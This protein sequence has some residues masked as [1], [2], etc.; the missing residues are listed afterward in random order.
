MTAKVSSFR[1]LKAWQRAMDLVPEVYQLTRRFP[2]EERYVLVDQVRRAVVSIPANISEGH[3]RQHTREFVQHLSS[4]RGSL[5]ELHTLLLIAQ[6]L[7][8]IAETDLTT[9][10]QVITEIRKILFGLMNRLQEKL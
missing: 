3:G 2:A 10:E 1:D 5:A 4:A 6:L 9:A 8:Y 7:G